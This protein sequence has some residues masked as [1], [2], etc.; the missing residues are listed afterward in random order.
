[1][2]NVVVPTDSVGTGAKLGAAPL[3]EH[4]IQVVAPPRPAPPSAYHPLSLL[5]LHQARRRRVQIFAIA[6]QDA[7]ACY[8]RAH[9]Q[10]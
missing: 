4:K 10:V 3:Y 2:H 9:A 7:V 8:V 5:T 1:M 6:G